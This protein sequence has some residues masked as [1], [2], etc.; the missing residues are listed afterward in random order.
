MEVVNRHS[1]EVLYKEVG[2]MGIG[3][4]G[5]V[6]FQPYVY[7]TNKVSSVSMNK[8]SKI[9]DDV[10]ESKVDYRELTQNSN[11][12]KV[13]Q[14]LDF[15]GMLN[16]QM[17]KGLSNASRIMKPAINAEEEVT[18]QNVEAQDVSLPEEAPSVNDTENAFM[19]QTDVK[20]QQA[21]SAYEMF[22]TA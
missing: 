12:L 2:I 19:Q 13:G 9:S 11:P 18:E 10:L 5:G 17:Q 21:I 15:Q 7:N 4:I 6:T 8:L 16:A 20:M 1:Y 22:M 3:A 14:T